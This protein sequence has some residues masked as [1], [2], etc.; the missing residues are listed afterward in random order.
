[1]NGGLRKLECLG[2]IYACRSHCQ[3]H[4]YDT[5]GNLKQDHDFICKYEGNVDQ[6]TYTPYEGD[7][8]C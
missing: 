4:C 6:K 2:Y 7:I 1:M 5:E 8:Q 3:K